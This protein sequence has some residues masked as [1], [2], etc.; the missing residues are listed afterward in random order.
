MRLHLKIILFSQLLQL[1]LQSL[2]FLQE[3]GVFRSLVNDILFI[4]I[5]EHLW[6]LLLLALHELWLVL[7][8]ITDV[9][10]WCYA[11]VLALPC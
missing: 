10:D 1:S 7:Q 8:A 3:E 5:F 4:W 11:E 9:L 6:L 2:H